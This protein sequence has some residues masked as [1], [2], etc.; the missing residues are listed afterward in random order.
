M[1]SDYAREKN[2]NRHN[3]SANDYFR[4]ITENFRVGH[5]AHDGLEIENTYELGEKSCP[6]RTGDSEPRYKDEIKDYV[7]NSSDRGVSDQTFL[8]IVRECDIAQ[9]NDRK[10]YKYRGKKNLER[11]CCGEIFTTKDKFHDR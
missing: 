7:R 2:G 3:T 10:I 11:N 9:N 5:R 8:P 1:Q 6:R 4:E